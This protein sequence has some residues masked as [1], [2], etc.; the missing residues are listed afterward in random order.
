MRVVIVGG[1]VVGL[2]L[3]RLLR[4]RGFEPVVLERNPPDS[5]MPRGF[6]LG[7]QG[8][9]ALEDVGLYEEVRGAGWDIAP[10]EDGTP[11][12]ICVDFKK[13]VGFLGDGVPVAH[14]E[15]VVELIEDGDRIVGAVTEG[16]GGRAEVPADL[17]VAC[18]GAG[19]PTREMAGLPVKVTELSGGAFGFLS[20][21]IIDRSFAMKYLSDGNIIGLLGWPDGSAGW[22]TVDKLDPEEALAPGLDAFK[23]SFRT[24]LPEATEALDGV[25]SLDQVRYTHPR[26]ISA[27]RWWRP[28]AVILGDAAH[29]FGPET[30][31]SAGLGLGDAH[32]LAEAI[33]QNPDDPDA[34]CASYQMWREPVV[35]PYEANDPGLQGTADVEN[36]D[37]PEA[38]RWP[39][40]PS[41]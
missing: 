3:G 23:N 8:F 32:A 21:T 16:P 29:F 15:S 30:G 20:P 39:P 28:G 7:F 4:D 5:H 6:M 9:P 34:A 24:L 1:G 35:R 17:V 25:T 41:A 40:V 38:E 22:W 19:S 31:V 36:E 18:D 11:V 37:R 33:K 2:L 10:R 13:F 27:E 12:A 14:G 26:V